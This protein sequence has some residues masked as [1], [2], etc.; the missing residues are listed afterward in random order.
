[1]EQKLREAASSLPEAE[2][3]FD[4]VHS[5][6][7]KTTV[8]WRKLSLIAACFVLVTCL[9]FGIYGC[10]AEIKEY[11]EA[12]AFFDENQLSTEGLSR[13]DIKAV[14]RDITTQSF[15]Y[16]K[17]AEVIQNSLTIEQV[18]GYQ[19]DQESVTPEILEELWINANGQFAPQQN[20]YQYHWDFAEKTHGEFKYDAVVQTRM[21]KYEGETLVWSTAV[22]DFRIDG[23]KV[24]SDGLIIYGEVDDSFGNQRDYPKL[25]KI[26]SDGN[27][28][29]V[30][31]L[32]NGFENE[33]IS[34]VVENADGTYAVF[35]RG[36][37]RYLCCGQYTPEGKQTSFQKT[38]IGKYGI[39]AAARLGED[40]IVLLFNY[41]TNEHAKILKVDREGNATESFSYS[42][43][44][45]YYYIRDMIEFDGKIYLSAYCVP[46]LENEEDNAGGRY[47]IAAIMNYLF[48][49]HIW[50][51]S[52]EE[53]TP[54]VRAN[55]TAMLLVCDAEGGK[56][57]E[58]YSVEGCQGGSLSINEA[59][60][61]LWDVESF[62]TT[63]YSPT[64]S[65]FSLR[66]TCSIFLYT[67]ND[68]GELVAQE[69]TDRVAY[70][71]Q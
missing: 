56:P 43:D 28:L 47:E 21:E 10:A 1:M 40:Y 36:D 27:L 53:L 41:D 55:Y 66:G 63:E 15:T 33:Y 62:V 44:D 19:I 35:S 12:V 22:K 30:E 45:A 46:V 39:L 9:G 5:E 25:G 58:F 18:G 8:P 60:E 6:A 16:S 65:A 4:N 20:S 52:S 34:A 59:G 61:L 71:W 49:N 29:W 68:R 48:D 11:N 24:V 17:T 13:S 37:F 67:F 57:R 42:S 23:Y 32:S 38:D 2:L 70:Y 64:T 31:T 54:L 50:E 7:P 51:I 26:D 3:S 14:Y 69:Q